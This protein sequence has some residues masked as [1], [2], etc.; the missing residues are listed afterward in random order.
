MSLVIIVGLFL[1]IDG[2][3]YRLIIVEFVY[4]SVGS[5]EVK[6]FEQAPLIATTTEFLRRGVLYIGVH[7]AHLYTRSSLATP[8][9]TV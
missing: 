7:Y 2:R 4:R 6:H 1:N 3:V 5:I 9:F 8:L